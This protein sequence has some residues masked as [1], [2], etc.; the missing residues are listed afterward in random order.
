MATLT[1]DHHNP[2]RL[3]FLDILQKL[4]GG[5][6]FFLD[7]NPRHDNF[8]KILYLIIGH[9]GQYS[10]LLRFCNLR[11]EL[12][13]KALGVQPKESGAVPTNT[14]QNSIIITRLGC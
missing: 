12:E 4:I 10:S 8:V 1:I 5:M 9:A 7:I 2:P 14:H 6:I 3:C 11:V 13:S